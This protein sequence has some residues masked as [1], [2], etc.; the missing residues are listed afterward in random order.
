VQKSNYY[1]QAVAKL[2]DSFIAH[3]V[4]FCKISFIYSAGILFVFQVNPL[5]MALNDARL[6]P[7]LPGLPESGKFLIPMIIKSH[8]FRTDH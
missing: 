3:I 2:Q 1:F 5:A 4:L 8:E 7:I 6:L